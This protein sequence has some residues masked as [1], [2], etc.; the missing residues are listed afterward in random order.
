MPGSLAV[1]LLV[2]LAIAIAWARIDAARPAAPFAHGHHRT[3][4]IPAASGFAEAADPMAGAPLLAVEAQG[5]SFLFAFVHKGEEEGWRIY[6]L[7]QPPY[8]SRVVGP[9]ETHRHFDAVLRL[10]FVCIHDDRKPVVAPA[11]AMDLARM[12]A[13]GT[14]RYIDTGLAF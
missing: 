5:R 8:G 9:H 1:I 6:I 10:H 3:P 14:V 13:D 4:P 7:R 12:W 2:C 11:E